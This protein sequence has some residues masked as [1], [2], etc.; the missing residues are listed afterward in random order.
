MQVIDAVQ[1]IEPL[2]LLRKDW[3]PKEAI[4]D[5]AWDMY[6]PVRKAREKVDSLLAKAIEEEQQRHVAWVDGLRQAIGAETTRDQLVA[7]VKEA[8]QAA[9]DEG[10]FAGVGRERL[11]Q[12]LDAFSRVRLDQCLDAIARIRAEA[13]HA[14]LLIELGRDYRELMTTA[15][16]FTT[17]TGQFLEGSRKRVET[18]I[19]QLE[20]A[21]ELKAA[22]QAIAES[23]DQLHALVG[24]IAG[25]AP[26][27]GDA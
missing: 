13:D 9:R 6:A 12:A 3:R 20:G 27:G 16:E 25:S 26:E 23:L 8:M 19:A 18:E 2:R 14:A 21:G 15:D 24:E 5:D 10:V 1:V 11:E 17:L 4:P 7:A 22:Q